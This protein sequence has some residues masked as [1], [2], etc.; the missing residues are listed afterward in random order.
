MGRYLSLVLGLVL[1]AF[2]ASAAEDVA[3]AV[4]GTVKH[5]SATA[6]TIVVKTADGTEHTFHFVARTSIHGTE[7]IGKGA[8]DA[9]RA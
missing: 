1:V 3:S 7:E 6:K 4:E 8:D 9:L 5:I 2:I